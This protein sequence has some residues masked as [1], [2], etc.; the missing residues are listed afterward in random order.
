M[1]VLQHKEFL[2]E[3]LRQFNRPEFVRLDPVCIPHRFTKRQDIEIAGFLAALLAWGQRQTIINKCNELMGFMGNEPHNFVRYHKP[4]DLKPMKDFVHRTFNSEDLYYFIRFLHLHYTEFDSLEDA[5]PIRPDATDV[6]AALTAFESLFFSL[7]AVPER[8]R[9]HVASPARRSACKRLN[10]F[11]R[12]MVRKDEGGIDFGIW[13][14][15]QPRQLVCPI[16]LHVERVAFRLGLL[17]DHHRNWEAALQL[18]ANLRKFDPEDPV[19]YDIALFS[20]GVDENFN[21]SFE[22]RQ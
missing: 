1:D 8:T 5:F 9:I 10:M 21:R 15:I 17:T 3:K 7:P 4:G 2:D 14:R 11:L 16:D 12:W 18:T 6:G 20:I 22:A 19:K 13:S